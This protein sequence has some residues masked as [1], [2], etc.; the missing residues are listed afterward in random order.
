[1]SLISSIWW[2]SKTLACAFIA[3]G[4]TSVTSGWTYTAGWSSMVPEWNTIAPGGLN[5]S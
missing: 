2:T 3:P 1:M 5:G 4:Q